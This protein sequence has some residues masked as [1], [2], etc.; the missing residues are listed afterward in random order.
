L[1]IRDSGFGIREKWTVTAVLSPRTQR[2]SSSGD[3]I[4][5]F[6]RDEIGVADARLHESPIPNPKSRLS[7]LLLHPLRRLPAWR[8]RLR[9]TGMAMVLHQPEVDLALLQAGLEHHDA[10]TVAE[11]VL[12][13]GALTGERLA[14]RV[15][16]VVVVRQLGH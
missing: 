5:R 10:R 9:A 8:Q 15:E 13:A 4:P 7:V 14:D 6:A 1:G 11:A 12:A 3:A 2:G 16:V